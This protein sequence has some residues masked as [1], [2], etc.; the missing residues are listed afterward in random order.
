MRNGTADSKCK[1]IAAP[2]EK[3][4]GHYR[5]FATHCSLPAAW[6]NVSLRKISEFY[7]MH[8]ESWSPEVRVR[9]W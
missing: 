4:E 2:D 6:Y 7:T 9:A 8:V 1:K 3:I 5:N